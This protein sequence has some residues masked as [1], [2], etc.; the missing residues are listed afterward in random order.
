MNRLVAR[1]GSL[2]FRPPRPS[3]E[4]CALATVVAAGPFDDLEYAKQLA[5]MFAG[6]QQ[7]RRTRLVMLGGGTRRSH[8]VRRAAERRLQTRLVLNEDCAGPQRSDLLAA[9]D[10]VIPSP[11][12]T[13]SALMEM[14][15]AGRA[16]VASASPATAALVMPHSAGLLYAP[17]D[18]SAMTAAVVRLLSQPELRYQMGSR[19]SQVARAHRLQVLSQQSP[20]DLKKYA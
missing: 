1:A 20:E 2:G 14:M 11:T 15:A 9:A 8:V 6:V 4:P 3:A 12:S 17:G 18:V 13:P 5:A 10:V 7:T 19:A 16:V